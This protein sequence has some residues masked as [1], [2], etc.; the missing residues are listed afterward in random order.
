[1]EMQ[2]EKEVNYTNLSE[3]AD[4][5]IKDVHKENVFSSAK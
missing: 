3:Y 4:H 1:M 5:Y 2:R